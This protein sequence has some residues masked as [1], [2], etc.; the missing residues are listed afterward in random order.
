M[1]ASQVGN[2][3]FKRDLWRLLYGGTPSVPQTDPLTAT[4][5]IVGRMRSDAT[6]GFKD[7]IRRFNNLDAVEEDAAFPDAT[8]KG[9]IVKGAKLGGAGD[10]DMLTTFE[11]TFRYRVRT[12][13][14]ELGQFDA[15]YFAEKTL[16]LIG[17]AAN[18]ADDANAN[19]GL[20]DFIHEYESQAMSANAMSTIDTQDGSVWWT[21]TATVRI[22]VRSD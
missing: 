2:E 10:H 1:P 9:K 21:V 14:E 5:G 17:D 18:Q 8:I 7:I 22:T 3:R 20:G 13:S 12:E 15:A 11:V 6:R 16:R 19:F 4:N